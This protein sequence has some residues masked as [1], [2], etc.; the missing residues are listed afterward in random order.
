MSKKSKDFAPAE[1]SEVAESAS[2]APDPIALM[3]EIRE[4]VKREIG[5]AAPVRA[6]FAPSQGNFEGAGEKGADLINA[7]ELRFLNLNYGYS[8]TALHGTVLTSHRPGILG[9]LIVAT[10]RRILA[11]LRDGLLKEYFEREREYQAHLVRFLNHTS[12]HIAERDGAIFWELIRKIDVDI[13]KSLERIE[14]IHDESMASLRTVERELHGALG[15]DVGA[16]SDR[17]GIVHG[18]VEELRAQLKVVDDV[19]RGMEGILARY[20]AP[21]SPSSSDS[22]AQPT[23]ERK[24]N[25]SSSGVSLP[26][27]LHEGSAPLSYLLLEN[28]FRG[29]EQE[30]T[31]RLEIYPPYFRGRK[32]PVLEIGGGRGELQTLLRAEGINSFSV[33][34]DRAMVECARAKGVDARCG[35]GIAFLREQANRSLG[36]VVAIQVVEH[37]TY[38]QLRELVELAARKVEVGGRVIFET[39]NPRSL[40]ALSSNYFRDPTH[41][42]P[43]HPDSLA[44]L[45]QLAGLKV[46]EVQ[47]L[48]PVP[49]EACLKSL[50]FDP[51]MTPRWQETVR[52]FNSNIEQLNELLFG[53]QD[54]SIVA[55]V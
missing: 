25:T 17:V 33:D 48:S 43:Q 11:W 23:A 54:F 51:Y 6:A 18:G 50:D 32:G 34:V 46:K 26:S 44:Y 5:S 21:S 36:G 55:E 19:V 41:V 40:V 12:R 29:S 37:L 20:P 14:R 9:R 27:L 3:Q 24:G 42:F 53:F 38:P 1:A 31:K 7:E 49:T 30:I 22:L 47:Y 8:A 35:D 15:R 52:R 2:A 16:V 28:R 45:L 4:R 39:I 10:K 13:A